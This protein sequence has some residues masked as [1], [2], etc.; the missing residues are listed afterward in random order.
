MKKLLALS[1]LLLT[2]SLVQAQT[3]YVSDKLETP[4]RAGAALRYK[5]IRMVPGGA[6]LT[7]LQTD[8]ESGYSLV[9]T[10]ENTQGWIATRDLMDTPSARDSLA[11]T[12]KELERTA[13][14]N[15]LLK[16]Q[17]DTMM[18]HGGDAKTSFSQILAEN[19]RLSQQ[20]AEIRKI[21]SGEVNLSEQNK[22]LHERVVSLERELQLVQQ[23][24][25]SLAD[26]RD[27]TMFL[28]GAG[29]LLG[30][31]LLG[32]TLT[33]LRWRKRDHWGSL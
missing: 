10:A 16:K 32:L 7:V 30:G 11:S 28:A 12:Q 31:I 18:V 19:E 33:R 22:T 20:L 21:N 24:N 27:H 17:I 13:A 8:A 5:I 15:A 3:R 14:E 29:V 6:P 9:R 23:E 26:S 25:Q 4:L 2:A 1:L